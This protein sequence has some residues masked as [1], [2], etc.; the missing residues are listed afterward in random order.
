MDPPAFATSL[1]TPWGKAAEVCPSAQVE[2]FDD[3]RHG[4][5]CE[6]DC[7]HPLQT[8]LSDQG[9]NQR[10]RPEPPGTRGRL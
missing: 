1:K 3:R 6:V 5:R 4:T 2:A 7:N 8:H 9:S 10:S